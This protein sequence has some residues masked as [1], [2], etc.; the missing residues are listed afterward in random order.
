VVNNMRYKKWRIK[1]CPT[2]TENWKDKEDKQRC[3]YHAIVLS[4]SAYFNGISIIPCIHYIK[5]FRKD[6]DSSNE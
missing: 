5:E 2:C 6:R 1:Q 4:E 3:A